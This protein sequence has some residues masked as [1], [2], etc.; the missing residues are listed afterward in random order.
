ML[1]ALV[2]EHAETLFAEAAARLVDQ[3]LPD[4]PY[5]QWVFSFPRRLRVALASDGALWSEVLRACVRKVFVYQRRKAR[6]LGIDA[7][8]TLAA[9]FLQRFGSLLQLNPHGHAFVP[10]AVWFDGPDGAFTQ[11][12][13]PPPTDDEVEAVG[14]AIVK[15]VLRIVARAADRAAIELDDEPAMIHALAE[16]AGTCA[17]TATS[18]D[19]ADGVLT[20]APR[21]RLAALIQTE[22]GVFSIHAGT[23]VAAGDRAGLERLLRYGGRPP[24]SHK[25]LSIT[26]T[27]KLC[28][29]LRKPYYTGQTE[30]VLEP[31]A[32]LRRLAALVPPA[33]QNQ[34]RYYRLLAAQAHDRD[35]L[36]TLVPTGGGDE[37]SI[38]VAEASSHPTATAS[39]YRLRWAQL[40]ARV[41]GHQVLICPSCGHARTIIAAITER[42]VAAKLLVHLGLPT[43]VPVLAQAR[44]PPQADLFADDWSVA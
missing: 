44:A 17:P 26:A 7:P 21:K 20:N 8:K 38:A 30:V 25:R 22:L 43:D 6:A 15:A 5:R 33:R 11:R 36:L 24:L 27:G 14:I 34:V 29:R 9:C 35:R 3:R 37:S 41:F 32:L 28:Y 23:S 12:E 40:L 18:R 4:A 10:D 16:A 39:G 13:L 2:R 19:A 1:Y 42:D 31:V